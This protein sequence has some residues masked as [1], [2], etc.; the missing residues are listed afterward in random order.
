MQASSYLY[1]AAL[2]NELEYPWQS[3]K[4]HV[5]G[6]WEHSNDTLNLQHLRQQ[7]LA[8]HVTRSFLLPTWQKLYY[9]SCKVLIH[10]TSL[11]IP[12]GTL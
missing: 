1:H 2:Y 3:I 10:S 9:V 12:S 7:I 4:S 8:M 11:N 6:A 5:M